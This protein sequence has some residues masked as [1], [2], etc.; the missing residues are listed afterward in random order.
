MIRIRITKNWTLTVQNPKL[1]LLNIVI[2]W[3]VLMLWALDL[4]PKW[5]Y[6]LFFMLGSYNTY[7]F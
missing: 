3:V 1:L 4:L 7:Y 2:T 6:N 5:W